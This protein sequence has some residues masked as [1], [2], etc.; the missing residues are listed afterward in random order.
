MLV[1]E[2]QMA[3]HVQHTDSFGGTAIRAV[4]GWHR[5]AL[6]IIAVY[7]PPASPANQSVAKETMDKV[8]R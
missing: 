2:E 5:K 1:L 6:H 3:C 8:L 4:L 7:I